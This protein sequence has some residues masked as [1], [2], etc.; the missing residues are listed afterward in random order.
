MFF[1]IYKYNWKFIDNRTILVLHVRSYIE[2][3]F[4]KLFLPAKAKFI[5]SSS[6]FVFV[7]KAI[8]VA[9]EM[10]AYIMGKKKKIIII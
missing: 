8:S 3:G 9:A 4:P 6:N 7:G 2:C 10:Q 1:F 5:N